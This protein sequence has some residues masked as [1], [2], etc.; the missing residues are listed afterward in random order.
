MISYASQQRG[1]LHTGS[2]TGYRPFQQLGSHYSSISGS[3]QALCGNEEGWGPISK[4]RYDFTP[5]FVDVW[6][7]TVSVYALILGPLAIWWLLRKKQSTESTTKNAHFW[8]KQVN[9]LGWR[10]FYTRSR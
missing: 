8:I 6:V 2:F 7:A 3:N 1:L 9:A 4:Y 5:C 10:F